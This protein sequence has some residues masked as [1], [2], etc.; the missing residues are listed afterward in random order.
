MKLTNCSYANSP[1]IVRK[2]NNNNNINNNNN[3]SNQFKVH[4][5]E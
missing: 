4:N 3:T 5:Q 2:Y 1:N